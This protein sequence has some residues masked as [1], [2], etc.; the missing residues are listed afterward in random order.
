MPAKSKAQQKFMGMVHAAQKGEKPASKEVAKVAKDMPKKAAKD[1]ASTKHKG[2]PAKV[3]KSKTEE[4]LLKDFEEAVEE[5]TITQGPNKGKQWSSKTPG[6]TNPSFPKNGI[7]P[8]SGVPSPDDGATAPPPKA[9]SQK[10]AEVDVDIDDQPAVAESKQTYGGKG[11]KKTKSE[12]DAE[13][14]KKKEKEKFKKMAEALIQIGRLEQMLLEAKKAK[15][16]YDGDGEIESE[17]DEV[18]GSRMKAAKKAG[19]MEEG[20]KPDYIDL[21]KDGNKKETMKKAA[22]DKAKGKSVEEGK[23]EGKPGKNFAKIANKAA[24]E[25]GSKAAGE[26]VAGAVKAKL[27]KQ[28][29]LEE[30][31]KEKEPEGLYSKKRFE[32]DS[33]RVARLAKEKRQAE[34]KK[35]EEKVDEGKSKCTC[36][37]SGKSK[38]AVHGKKKDA[39]MESLFIKLQN[40]LNG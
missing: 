15:K 13:V 26:R 31:N 4:S 24:K 16:D 25:Y 30:A 12:H 21:D 5:A 2:L 29:K 23:D 27:A 7:D 17:K 20:A 37:E 22:K 14:K 35:K 39:Y 34:K 18:W 40:Q 32:T 36:E 3:K 9:K 10:R 38:C 6:V 33:Q 19:K 11:V 28:G 1:F 8:K